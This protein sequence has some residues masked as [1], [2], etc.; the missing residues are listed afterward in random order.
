M[1]IQLNIGDF[2]INS[3]LNIFVL[4]IATDFYDNAYV[5]FFHRTFGDNADMYVF[6]FTMSKIRNTDFVMIL[7]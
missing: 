3:S 2:F 4:Y 7:V 5:C 1:L 6:T